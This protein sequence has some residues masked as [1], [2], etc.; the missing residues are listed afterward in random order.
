MNPKWNL[1]RLYTSFESEELAKDLDTLE[2]AIL[3]MTTFCKDSFGSGKPAAKTL[4]TYNRRMDELESLMALIGNYGHLNYAVDTMNRDAIRL[5]GRIEAMKPRLAPV[6]A[7]YSRWL[8]GID[9]LEALLGTIP[10]LEPYRFAILETRQRARHLLGDE[11]EVL[12]AALQNT[13]SN[14]WNKLQDATIASLAADYEGGQV[15]ISIIRGYADSPAAE[16]RRKAY[17]AELASYPKIEEISAACLNAIKGEVLTVAKKRGYASPL[18][19]T[20]EA[21]RMDKQTLDAMLEAIEEYLPVFRAYLKKKAAL[22]GHDSGLPFYDL[23][24]PV[25]GMD[26]S[27]AYEEAAGFIIE[28]FNGFSSK[29]GSYATK[30]FGEGWIDAEPR[31]GKVSGAFCSNLHRIG[32][33]RIM[34]N[35]TGTYN[36]VTTLAHELGHGYHGDCL[37]DAC[38]AAS[39][40]PMPLAETASIFAETIVYHAVLKEA[41]S[42]EKLSIIENAVMGATQ[43]IVDIYSRYLF[44]SALFE[45]RKDGALSSGELKELMLEAQKQA[46]GDGLDHRFLHPWMWACKPHYY[47]AG[48]NFYNFPY[49]FGLLFAKGLYALYLKEGEAFLPKYDALL[50]A[51]GHSSVADVLAMAGFDAHEPG[52]FR[53]SLELVKKDIDYILSV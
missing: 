48:Y 35:F 16:V 26:R 37:K 24:A 13:G 44:E 32:E 3:E 22:L 39:D 9:G 51:T 23:F 36:D 45:K 20:L 49:A 18:D 42:E 10:E 14:A 27:Y 46:Y 19:M 31:T 53:Q 28:Q 38:H 50:E 29:L 12:L 5:I 17:E 21:S 33:S 43:V 8:A 11:E 2:A 4:L 25:G 30:A 52:F 1:D 41:S 15:P 7:A 40:Y 34:A 6:Y 47:Y